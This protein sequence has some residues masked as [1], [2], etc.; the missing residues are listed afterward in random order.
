VYHTNTGDLLFRF[1]PK[2]SWTKDAGRLVALPDKPF[3]MALIGAEKGTMLDL[4]G[5]KAGRSLPHWNGITTRDGIYGIRCRALSHI[6]IYMC[7]VFSFLY[8]FF[9][10]FYS[11]ILCNGNRKERESLFI[12]IS[13]SDVLKL[14]KQPQ[15][16]FHLMIT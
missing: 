10:H 9:E 7:L 3:T 5:R 8:P 2:V 14:R 15:K 1:S 6:H 13:L 4:K 16:S 12:F 11:V